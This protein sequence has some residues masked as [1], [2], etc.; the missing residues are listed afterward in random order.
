MQIKYLSPFN[1]IRE[2]RT[3]I[4]KLEDM[5]YDS[6][7]RKISDKRHN[8]ALYIEQ[9]KGLSPLEKL[10]QGYSYVSDKRGRTV[11]SIEQVKTDE[12]LHVYVKDGMI[13]AKV[14]NRQ[15]IS[16]EGSCE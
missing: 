8:L 16:W 3:Y 14:T 10:N 4:L 1:Q 12:E 13:N 7:I 15:K 9:M 11:Y 6:M 5:L 2:K